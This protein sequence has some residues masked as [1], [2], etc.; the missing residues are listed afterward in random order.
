MLASLR[1]PHPSACIRNTRRYYLGG[2]WVLAWWTG[3]KRDLLSGD[4]RPWREEETQ[5][6]VK[7]QC[8]R[9]AGAAAQT[10]P[11]CRDPLYP[12]LNKTIPQNP[13]VQMERQAR[14][15]RARFVGSSFAR[16]FP[17][18]CQKPKDISTPPGHFSALTCRSRRQRDTLPAAS[19]ST[20]TRESP[21]CLLPVLAP[22]QCSAAA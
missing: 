15:C 5:T 14:A 18:Q 9:S 7:P 10:A 17:H 13:R 6:R 8:G 21:C 2:G 11:G 19:V 20:G 3:T 16:L 1:V 12:S 22:K 4:P